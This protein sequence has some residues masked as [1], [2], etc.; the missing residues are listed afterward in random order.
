MFYKE[1][2]ELFAGGKT[3]IE[4]LEDVEIIRFIEKDYPVHMVRVSSSSVAVD[5]EEDLIKVRELLN[6]S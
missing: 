4:E 5:T 3:P 1:E 2:L 6:A